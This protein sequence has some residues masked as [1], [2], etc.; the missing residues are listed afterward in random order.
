M[1]KRKSKKSYEERLTG[2]E[3]VVNSPRA[4]MFRG[5]RDLVGPASD[6]EK[7]LFL[8]L[9]NFGLPAKDIPRSLKNTV[10]G[11]TRKNDPMGGITLKRM[12]GLEGPALPIVR[13][14]EETIGG[15]PELIEKLSLI[16]D[17]LSEK[18]AVFLT[19]LREDTTKKSLARLMAESG[20]SPTRI[21]KY[22]AEGAMALG[23]VEAAIAISREQP[24]IVKD[25]VRNA[26][27]S[28][29]ICKVCVG[30][31]KVKRQSNDKKEDTECPSCEGSGSR[32]I[33][34]KHK[35]YAMDK[36]LELG[37]LVTPPQKGG[38]NVAVNQN[39]AV[40]AG[41]GGFME[42][43]LKTSDEILYGRKVIDVLPENSSAEPGEAGS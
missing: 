41:R 33:S 43:V 14:F 21:L 20:V 28:T 30:T 22:Y 13:K 19:S 35:E 27:D 17:K 26:L 8:Q 10:I 40:S 4:K 34:S 5:L 1:T 3:R 24:S 23:K 15:R 42:R 32:I 36:V 9:T 37:G 18:E 29:K 38:V 39:V 2:L 11:K 12:S 7:L 25:L 31:G 6:K 16:E